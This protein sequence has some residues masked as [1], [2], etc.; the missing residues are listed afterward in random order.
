M[1]NTQAQFADQKVLR[2]RLSHGGS[3]RNI[4]LGRRERPLSTKHPI[5]LVFKANRHVIPGGFR[6]HRRFQL[7]HVLVQRYALKFFVKVEQI[8]IQGDHWHL[9]VRTSRRS[10]FQNF[11]RVVAGQTAQRFLG[12]GLVR[13]PTVTDTPMKRR[14]LW[15]Q[16]PFTRVV[17]GYRAYRTVR[18]YVQLNELEALG[19]IPYRKA[20]LNGLS[21]EERDNLWR[22]AIPTIKR[23]FATVTDTHPSGGVTDTPPS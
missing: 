21:K 10:G 19:K 1:R 5:H 23:V 17:K 9:V 14:K 11:L 16:R 8:S 13:L 2:H 12:E 22:G 18:D 7:I 20:R 4:R 3:L 6:T 15:L